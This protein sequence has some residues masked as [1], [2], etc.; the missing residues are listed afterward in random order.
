MKL[1]VVI[2][3]QQVFFIIRLDF[4][5]IRAYFYEVMIKVRKTHQNISTCRSA[6]KDIKTNEKKENFRSRRAHFAR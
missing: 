6:E 2:S 4:F 1:K 3:I 5:P